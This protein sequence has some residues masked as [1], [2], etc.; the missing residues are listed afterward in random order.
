MAPDETS[1][2]QMEAEAEIRQRRLCFGGGRGYILLPGETSI[3]QRS[4][5]KSPIAAAGDRNKSNM[6]RM[7][8]NHP[9]RVTTTGSTPPDQ[10]L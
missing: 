4:P 2:V 7:N 1:L 9:A 8:I 5:V 10:T 3:M 6:P